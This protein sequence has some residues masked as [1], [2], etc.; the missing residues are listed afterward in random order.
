MST[1]AISDCLASLSPPFC[2]PQFFCEETVPIHLVIKNWQANIYQEAEV[3]PSDSYRIKLW[4]MVGV[5][6]GWIESD[7]VW[8]RID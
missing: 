1:S 3:S 8:I 6:I 4:L 2:F 7:E 5:V